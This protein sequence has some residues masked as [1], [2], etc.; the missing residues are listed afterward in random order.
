ME[1]QSYNELIMKLDLS[2]F[3]LIHIFRVEVKNSLPHPRS[4]WFSAGFSSRSVLFE[5]LYLSLWPKVNICS[6]CGTVETY[7]TRIH[8]DVGSIPG[9]APWVKDPVLP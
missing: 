3:S 8:E 1:H 4:R 5:L 9:L 7:P 6:H 2:I